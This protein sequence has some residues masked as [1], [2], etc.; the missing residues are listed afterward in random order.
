MSSTRSGAGSGGGDARIARKVAEPKALLEQALRGKNQE[1]IVQA[2]VSCLHRPNYSITN[3]FRDAAGIKKRA[4]AA[5]APIKQLL[6]DWTQLDRTMGACLSL[7]TTACERFIEGTSHAF[8][9]LDESGIVV[10]ANSKMLQLL[11]QCV[12][13]DL[14]AC[15]GSM[16][17]QIRQGLASG[18]RRLYQLDLISGGRRHPVLAEFQK[19]NSRGRSGGFAF[20]IDERIRRGRT[21]GVGG[22]AVRNAEIGFDPSRALR[23]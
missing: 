22:G 2:L 9:E 17:R 1:R 13:Q 21:Q 4:A 11:P 8:C 16:S 6:M 3:L 7:A 23:K 15:F 19:F 18:Q 5:G 14:P 20:L 10:Y 12:G